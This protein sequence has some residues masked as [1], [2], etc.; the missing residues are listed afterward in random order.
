MRTVLLSIAAI[1]LLMAP[2]AQ[3]Q[4]AINVPV[5]T[6]DMAS[7]DST[8]SAQAI[9]V[10]PPPAMGSSPGSAAGT[11]DP[12]TTVVFWN[13]MRQRVK[14]YSDYAAVRAFDAAQGTLSLDDGTTVSF[15][16][17]F[18]F[19]DT[20]QPGQPVTIYYFQD[21]DG[22]FVLS[23]IDMGTQGTSNGG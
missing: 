17:N 9:V 21:R 14:T 13:G 4:L 3:A 11:A 5:T 12:S 23:T 20:P 10:T 1:L 18:A 19:L 7:A 2:L 16:A 22:T 6:P 8:P 15:P